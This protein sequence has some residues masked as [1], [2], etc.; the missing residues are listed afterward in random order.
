MNVL[1][2]TESHLET[3][4]PTDFDNSWTS[5]FQKLFLFVIISIEISNSAKPHLRGYNCRPHTREGNVFR[6]KVMFSAMSV[7]LWR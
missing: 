7:N 6:G 1:R 2:S 4:Q 5:F 3:K